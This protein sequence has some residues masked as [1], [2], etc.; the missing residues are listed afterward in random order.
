[1]LCVRVR[2]GVKGWHYWTQPLPN[3]LSCYFHRLPMWVHRVETAMTFVLEGV[4]AVLCWTPLPG[5]ILAFCCFAAILLMINVSGNYGFLAQMTL[6]NALCL[7]NDD[8]VRW[9]LWRLPGG[10]V[11]ERFLE[12]AWRSSLCPSV[13]LSLDRLLSL[14]L[15]SLLPYVPVALYLALG[16]IPLVNTAHGRNP[17]EVLTPITDAPLRLYDAVVNASALAKLHAPVAS[18]VAWLYAV[19]PRA[20]AFDLALRYVKFGHMTKRRYE[21]VLQTSADGHHWRDV[22]LQGEAVHP[23]LCLPASARPPHPHAGL[24]AVVSFE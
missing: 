22:P 18:L 17:L 21:L 23:S 4:G 14:P 2:G 11:A 10:A 16:M 1:M 5:R 12:W 8:V 24:A 19:Y 7:L 3:P 20:Q 13:W 6:T 15:L 9:L